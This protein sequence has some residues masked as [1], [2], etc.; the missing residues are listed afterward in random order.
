MSEIT[1]ILNHYDAV[2]NGS[3]WHGDPI[4]QILD[5]ISAETAAARPLK[6]SH[7]IW[8]IVMHMTFWEGVGTQRLAGQRAGLVEELNFPAMPAPTSQNW[9]Q[10][11]GQ[12][13]A[14]NQQFRGALAKLDPAR[15]DD[16]SAAGKRTYY[17][18]AHGVIEHDIYHAGQI[19]LLRKMG[20]SA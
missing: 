4:W 6:G 3:P 9:E 17:D 2:L 16:L 12:F 11:L 8:E 20:T 15:L 1:R 10:T 5:G 13:R 14:S 19:A 18:E 7:T